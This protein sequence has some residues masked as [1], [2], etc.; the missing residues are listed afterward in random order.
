MSGLLFSVLRRPRFEFS[1]EITFIDDFGLAAE[2]VNF[3]S[4]LAYGLGEL[5][6]SSYLISYS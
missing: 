2:V 5:L 4:G 6:L 1:F 3:G